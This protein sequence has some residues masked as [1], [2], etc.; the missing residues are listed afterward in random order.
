MLQGDPIAESAFHHFHDFIADAQNRTLHQMGRVVNSVGVEGARGLLLDL[1]GYGGYEWNA[2]NGGPFIQWGYRLSDSML[3]LNTPSN[4]PIDSLNLADP[5]SI[6]TF[7]H[8]CELPGQSYECLARGPGSLG[9]RVASKL[10][11]M[12]T[13]GIGLPSYEFPNPYDTE[14]DPSYCANVPCTYFRGGYD[15]DVH[16]HLDWRTRSGIKFNAVQAELPRCIRFSSNGRFQIA[17]VLSIE[18]CSFL[19]DIFPD[20]PNAPMC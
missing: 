19:R 16:E 7:T 18:M 5:T 2:D 3:N 1:H 9:S 8:A 10:S 6:G 13:C 17:E 14:R 4:C 12:G 15:V 20:D 11:G